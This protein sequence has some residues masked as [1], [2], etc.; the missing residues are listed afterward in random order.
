VSQSDPDVSQRDPDVTREL[1]VRTAHDDSE[2]IAASVRPDN[3][4]EMAT[5]VNGPE[6]ETKI[7]RETTSGL[8]STADDYVVNLHVAAQCTTDHDTNTNI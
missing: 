3:T 6:I 4:D 5:D 7:T 1:V 2:A 8:H